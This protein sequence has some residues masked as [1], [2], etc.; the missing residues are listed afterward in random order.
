MKLVM[1]MTGLA[2]FIFLVEGLRD[3]YLKHKRRKALTKIL[4]W[5]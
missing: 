4:N 1:L 5:P 3:W 2:G